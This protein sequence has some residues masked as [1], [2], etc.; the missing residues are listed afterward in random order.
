MG[1]IYRLARP[2]ESELIMIP[3]S[4][5]SSCRTLLHLIEMPR[6]SETFEWYASRLV[7]AFY[8]TCNG[9]PAFIEC[10]PVLESCRALIV[11]Y[12]PPVVTY[13]PPVDNNALPTAQTS[14]EVINAESSESSAL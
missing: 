3:A 4:M 6:P 7:D 10:V 2:Y 1:Q 14:A 13:N 12:N 11:T 8:N 9:Q 5:L